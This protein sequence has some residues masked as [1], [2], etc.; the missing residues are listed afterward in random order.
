MAG[1]ST[2]LFFSCALMHPQKVSLDSFVVAGVSKIVPLK[3][4][5][6]RLANMSHLFNFI[7]WEL[8]HLQGP[9]RRFQLILGHFC[10]FFD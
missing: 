6:I 7:P 3:V 5:Y 4:F 1:V 10:V 8:I 2:L 9:Q